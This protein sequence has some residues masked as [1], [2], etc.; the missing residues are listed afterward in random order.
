MPLHRLMKM[1]ALF[2]FGLVLAACSSLGTRDDLKGPPGATFHS[3]KAP[4]AY[5]QCLTP[6]WRDTTVVGGQATVE[7]VAGAAGGL[8]MTLKIAGAPARVLDV[9]PKAGGSEVRY[10]NL[11]LDFGGGG[12]TKAKSAQ[13]I[14]GCL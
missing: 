12:A 13:A 4:A 1:L 3:R 5:A 14:E 7:T 10:W 6:L 8:R 2:A 9:V 11:S